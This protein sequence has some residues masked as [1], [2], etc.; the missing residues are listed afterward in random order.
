MWQISRGLLHCGMLAARTP[1]VEM[2]LDPPEPNCAPQVVA[3]VSLFNQRL[4]HEAHDALEI[5]WHPLRYR[6]SGNLYKALIQVAGAFHHLQ[7]ERPRPALALLRRAN[8]L[9]E[10][11]PANS[12]SGN[13]APVRLLIR[14]W[15]EHLESAARPASSP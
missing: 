1:S 3:Y 6:P 13:L 11:Y 12:E 14:E 10:P 2:T 5:V 15:I 4:Y 7:R 9:M 8:V